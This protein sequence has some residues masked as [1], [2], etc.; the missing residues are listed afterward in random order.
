MQEY[1][2]I[3]LNTSDSNYPSRVLPIF[4][5]IGWGPGTHKVKHM[6]RR[7]AQGSDPS[8]ALPISSSMAILGHANDPREIIVGS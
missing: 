4:P 2:V 1:L 6:H 5:A 8:D 3:V 7:S